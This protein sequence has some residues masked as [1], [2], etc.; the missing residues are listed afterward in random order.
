[1]GD[2]TTKTFDIDNIGELELEWSINTEIT[3]DKDPKDFCSA[4]GGGDEYI[5][6]VVFG[7]IDNSTG[8]DG[9]ADYTSMSTIV[10]LSE[11]Y[12]ITIVNGNVYTSD[13][14]GIW[15]DWNQDDDFEDAG[16]NVVCEVGNSGQGTYPIIVPDDAL[17]GAP[18]VT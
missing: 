14:L 16:E 5:S 11:T 3:S 2:A 8:E 9:Y 12:D 10:N 7:D 13:D 4:G 6:Q 18:V 17:P 1:M 15:V